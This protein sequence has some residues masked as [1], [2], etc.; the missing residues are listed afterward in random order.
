MSNVAQVI[1]M[2]VQQVGFPPD[3]LIFARLQ[4]FNRGE[5]GPT[6][7]ADQNGGTMQKKG[8]YE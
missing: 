5:D 6:S 4:N 7:Q 1:P 2:I 3:R 8:G